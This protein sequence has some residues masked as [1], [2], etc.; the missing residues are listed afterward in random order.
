[1]W[2]HRSVSIGA[3]V[4]AVP[5]H[6]LSHAFGPGPPPPDTQTHQANYRICKLSWP[7]LCDQ[8][9]QS[10]GKWNVVRKRDGTCRKG[11]RRKAACLRSK[12]DG[13]WAA[14]KVSERGAGEEE[15][16]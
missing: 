8:R 14:S 2:S 4:R 16:T 10:E 7:L 11:K 5:S 12:M 9:L 13:F 6:L 1:M 15:C 3:T